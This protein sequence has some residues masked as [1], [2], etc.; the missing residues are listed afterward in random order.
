MKSFINNSIIGTCLSLA[1]CGCAE[2][3]TV[4]GSTASNQEP[5]QSREER[6]EM[7]RRLQQDKDLERLAQEDPALVTGE[8]PADL[9]AKVYDDLEQ[10][11]GGDRSE[12]KLLRGESVQWSDGALG[13]AEPG[14]VYTQALVAGYWIV[15]EHDG[16]TY[17][18]RATARGYF[19]LCPGFTLD[20]EI[21][22]K[23]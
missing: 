18:Y 15:I 17:D 3:N 13:C 14:Q 19:K 6:I 4:D 5:P 2:S 22:P 10:R 8:V 16:K 9:L 20:R 7:R 23:M 11:T 21:M 1:L 12:F